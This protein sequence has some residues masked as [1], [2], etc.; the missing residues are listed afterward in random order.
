MAPSNLVTLCQQRGYLPICIKAA[1]G[2]YTEAFALPSIGSD[3]LSL[4]VGSVGTDG[5][6]DIGLIYIDFQG[7]PIP[8]DPTSTYS[9]GACPIS[10]FDSIFSCVVD[11]TDSTVDPIPVRLEVDGIGLDA[12]VT[13]YSL[14]DGTEVVLGPTAKIADDCDR[15]EYREQEVCVL[16]PSGDRIASLTRVRVYDTEDTSDGA[17]TIEWVAEEFLDANGLPYTLGA[18]ETIGSCEVVLP[19]ISEVCIRRQ[20]GTQEPARQIIP[21]IGGVLDPTMPSFINL[22]DGSP[23]AFDPATDSLSAGSCVVVPPERTH[24]CLFDTAT[25]TGREVVQEIP[26]TGNGYDDANPVYKLRPGGVIVSPSATEE[27]NEGPC[28]RCLTC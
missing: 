24:G 2:T 4:P 15:F 6:T 16:G 9:H 25:N 1:D 20:D 3:G 22:V 8:Y 10:N 19:Y 21:V 23:V 14:V 13:P 5:V 12:V 26:Y 28:T 27:F 17:A 11:P 18:G 7:N